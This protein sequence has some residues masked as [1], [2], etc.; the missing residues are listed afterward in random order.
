MAVAPNAVELTVEA[1]WFIAERLG[2]GSFPWVLAVTPPYRNESERAAFLAR[3]TDELTRLGVLTDGRVDPAVADWVRTVCHP[4][5]WLELR[6]VGI[7]S[8]RTDLLRG[9][10]ARR[11]ERTVV[12]LRNAQL[13]TCTAMA[14]DDPLALVPI[15]GVGLSGCRPARFAEFALPARVGARADEQLRAGAELAGVLDHLGVPA[16]AHA[17]VESVFTGPR[18]YVEIV[19]GC[20]RDG[21]S[22]T[23]EVGV[24]VV[25][26]GEGRVLVSP[27]RAFDGEWISTFTPGTPL[28]TAL[29]VENLNATL[30]ESRWFPSAHLSREF[31]H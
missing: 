8:G 30:P 9:I 6:Y 12:A 3:Q 27:Q 20:N 4:Q 28:A 11:G 31:T 22:T 29:A 23:S 21:V 7:A 13:I 26:S 1:A 5:R 16:S 25:D 15:V 10:V 17:L 2:A 19:A 14:V 18:R 24:A